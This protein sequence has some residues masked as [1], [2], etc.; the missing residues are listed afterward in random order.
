MEDE[1]EAA[2]LIF[3]EEFQHSLEFFKEPHEDQDQAFSNF[4]K[5]KKKK[6]YRD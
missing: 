5:D 4:Q 3:E 6:E 1:E 2:A